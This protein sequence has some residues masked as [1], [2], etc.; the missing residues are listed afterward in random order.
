MKLGCSFTA[1]AK[2]QPDQKS[3]ITARRMK[4]Y[5]RSGREAIVNSGAHSKSRDSTRGLGHLPGAIVWNSQPYSGRV[6]PEVPLRTS[7]HLF[8]EIQLLVLISSVWLL[9]SKSKFVL[10]R[11]PSTRRL[12]L[13]LRILFPLSC[14]TTSVNPNLDN[15]WQSKHVRNLRRQTSGA[16][17]IS[18]PS[19]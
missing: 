16:G 5:P 2:Q 19:E 13:L 9:S 12:I 14:A 4:A 11:P 7:Q 1:T 17:M 3:E 8:D 18:R 10:S 15:R 6:G